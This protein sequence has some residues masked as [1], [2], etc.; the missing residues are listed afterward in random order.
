MDNYLEKS[1][2]AV[3]KEMKIDTPHLLIGK[4]AHATYARKILFHIIRHEYRKIIPTIATMT[5]CDV[6]TV[7]KA[8]RVAEMQ[9][10]SD[11]AFL[12]HVNNVRKKLGFDSI[13]VEKEA[14]RKVPQEAKKDLKPTP[15]SKSPF[16]ITY[17]DLDE[18]YIKMAKQTAKNFMMDYGKGVNPLVDGFYSRRKK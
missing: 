6:S 15:Y 12:R 16:G 9:I 10:K 7:Y 13:K 11:Y 18:I 3:S 1:I 17:T 8:A 4:D 14:P 5:S 2:R